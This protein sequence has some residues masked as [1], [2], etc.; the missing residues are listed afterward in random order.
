MDLVFTAEV[1][2]MIAVASCF[3]GWIFGNLYAAAGKG[4]GERAAERVDTLFSLPAAPKIAPQKMRQKADQSADET[5][6][7]FAPVF[8]EKQEIGSA[9]QAMIGENVGV[10][11]RERLRPR[12]PLA[13]LS[14]PNSDAL[15]ETHPDTLPLSEIRAHA[16]HLL[17]TNNVWEAP[18]TQEQLAEFMRTADRKS[19]KLL[20]KYSASIEELQRANDLEIYAPDQ[21]HI[22]A[23]ATGSMP[24]LADVGPVCPNRS[25]AELACLIEERNEADH[26]KVRFAGVAC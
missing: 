2:G 14:D 16:R 6:P 5:A 11:P 18:E 3:G 26:P 9:A 4:T 21:R 12:P 1:W 19:V 15:S 13:P 23:Q 17:Q 8:A 10:R 20:S 25:L 22:F 7:H 24:R